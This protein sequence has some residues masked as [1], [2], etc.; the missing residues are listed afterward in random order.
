MSI[1]DESDGKGWCQPLD[2]IADSVVGA[3]VEV[4]SD[5]EI[6]EVLGPVEAHY[7]IVEANALF[8]SIPA[9][10]ILDG[11]GVLMVEGGCRE[12]GGVIANVDDGSEAAGAIGLLG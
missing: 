4:G 3:L 6:V 2:G 7:W 11:T 8:V 12:V 1:G 9:V 10:K 5:E